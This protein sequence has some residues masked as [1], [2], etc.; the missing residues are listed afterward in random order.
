MLMPVLAEIVPELAMPPAKIDIAKDACEEA[1]PPTR[2][3]LSMTTM[4]PVPIT[5]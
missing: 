3:V 5:P 4:P 1:L 2:M